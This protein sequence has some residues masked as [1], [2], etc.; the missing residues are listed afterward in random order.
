MRGAGLRSMTS[1]VTVVGVRYIDPSDFDRLMGNNAFSR[2]IGALQ[3][4]HSRLA[5]KMLED[6]MLRSTRARISQSDGHVARATR[7]KFSP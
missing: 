1:A 7:K 2:S 6:T 5:H 4:M 3:A